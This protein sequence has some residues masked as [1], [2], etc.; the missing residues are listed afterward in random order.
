MNGFI[1][2]CARP[3]LT[4]P[5]PL[6]VN[7]RYLAYPP[8]TYY[9]QSDQNSRGKV[10]T[11]HIVRN[12]IERVCLAKSKTLL[13]E[14]RTSCTTAASFARHEALQD[15]RPWFLPPPP[16]NFRDCSTVV[17]GC[18]T[19]GLVP[20]SLAHCCVSISTEEPNTEH[21]SLVPGVSVGRRPD[22]GSNMP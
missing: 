20:S 4:S 21:S 3:V 12:Q 8:P 22:P 17:E 11:D 6:L 13:H 19:P 14:V 10:H 5:P 18:A 15:A 2:P 7:S 9:L 16:N 1:A